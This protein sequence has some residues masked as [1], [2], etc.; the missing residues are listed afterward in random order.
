MTLLPADPCLLCGGRRWTPLPDPGPR[1][2]LSDWRTLDAP[3]GKATCEGCGLARR[4]AIGHAAESVYGSGYRLYAHPPGEARERARQEAYAGWMATAVDRPPRQILD[5]GCGNG[6][7][8]VALRERWP[9]ADTLGCDP[10]EESVRAGTGAGLGLRLWRGTSGDL[11]A[12]VAD[13]VVTV[14]V[15]EHTADPLAFLADLRRAVS[16]GGT[17]V[18]ICPDGGHPNLE[19]LFADH[20]YSLGAAHVSA[21]MARAGLETMTV[22]TA[23]PALGAFQMVTARPAV[24]VPDAA[25][26][27]CRSARHAYLERWARLDDRLLPRVEGPAVCFG[28]GEAAGLLRA[29]APQAWA[30]VAACTF[31]GAAPGAFGDLPIRPL[32]D[33]PRDSTLLLGVRP[34]D[35]PRLAARLGREF[36]RVAAWYDLVDDV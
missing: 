18:V 29:Y 17:V 24:D 10:S 12:G 2:M 4:H 23:P 32:A 14:N 15:I 1:S 33:V 3:L 22:R 20:L 6:S 35:Q 9:G 27:P 7:L 13:L 5:V 36:A 8:L 30:R 16:A 34:A 28:A 31:D 11:P 25:I 21:L 26:A 19:L